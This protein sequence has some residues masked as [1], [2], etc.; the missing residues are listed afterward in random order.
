MSLS[1]AGMSAACAPPA[2]NTAKAAAT[3]NFFLI[4]Y[5]RFV[6]FSQFRPMP[7]VRCIPHHKFTALPQPKRR[8]QSKKR[9]TIPKTVNPPTHNLQRSCN[10][11]RRGGNKPLRVFD[12]PPLFAPQATQRR[13]PYNPCP[14]AQP[15]KAA[16][17]RHSREPQ[18]SGAQ[19]GV[20]PSSNS[21]GRIAVAPP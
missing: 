12:P 1:L 19:L 14:A 11:C 8:K 16:K 20:M 2:V 7:P 15:Q 21:H 10:N 17:R 4:F 6:V 9:L 3:N 5:V 18:V 13:T